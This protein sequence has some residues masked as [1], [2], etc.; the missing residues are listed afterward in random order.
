MKLTRRAFQFGTAVAVAMSFNAVALAQDNYPS[1]PVHILVGAGPGGTADLYARMVA[2]GLTQRMGQPFVVDNVPGAN[3]N[4]AAGTVA[5]AD[6]DGYTLLLGAWNTHAINPHLYT[7]LTYDH[8]KDFEP[9]SLFAKGPLLLDVNNDIPAN[10][11]PELIE[12]LKKNPGKYNFGSTSLGNGTHLTGELFKLMT[13]VDIVHVPYRS[14]TGEMLAGLM[15]SEVQI[16]FDNIT[17]SLPQVRAG[18]I[19]ALAVT[20]AERSPAAPDIPT[21][22]EFVPGF[23]V[24]GWHAVFAPAGTPKEIVQRLSDGI[25]DIVQ[26]PEVSKKIIDNGGVPVGSSPEELLSFAQSETEKFGRIVRDA[27]IHID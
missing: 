27:G 23:D 7:N 14:G 3:S 18:S 1:R 17:S 12:F 15:R 6:P 16:A 9:I 4:I 10:S 2:E 11:V 19:K 13:G 20:S 26:S 25:R 24:S 21:I 5:K 22:A 8:I